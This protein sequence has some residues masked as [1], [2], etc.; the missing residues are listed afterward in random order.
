MTKGLKYTGAGR[1]RGSGARWWTLAAASV[2]AV[3]F[4]WII[5]R[6][7]TGRFVD[8]LRQADLTYAAMVP[9]SI[10]AEQ[11]ARAWKWRQL[12]GQIKWVRSLR[13]FGAI[14]AGYFASILVPLGISPIV[15]SWLVARME[16]LKM[17][18]VLAT[19]AIDRLTDGLVFSG[20]VAVVLIF[21]AIPGANQ[22][23]ALGLGLVGT[24]SAVGICL[25]GVAMWRWKRGSNWVNRFLGRIAPRLPARYSAQ[26][27]EAAKSFAHGVIWPREFSR[28]LG[29]VLAS[30]VIKLIAMTHF[31]FAGLAFGFLLRPLDYLFL[32][33][34]L[35]FLVILSRI[36]RVPGG[37]LIGAVFAFDLLGVSEERAL[38]AALLVRFSS[39][40]TVSTLGA[41]AFW[42]SNV[43][44]RAL[45]RAAKG[46]G[47]G[48]A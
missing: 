7:D 24:V 47:L 26:I 40:L 30:I 20:F 6:V 4:I 38:L 23:L 9:L 48:K 39:L 32:L 8:A 1:L 10:I 12:L 29:I 28:G 17:G 22:N 43:S 34:F 21:A 45:K 15:R 36:A 44:Y 2:G 33:V 19:A 41:F 5:S 11:L 46:A 25:I 27:L 18:T 3:L 42:R 14:M 37:F 13:L 16:G 31:L 35:G